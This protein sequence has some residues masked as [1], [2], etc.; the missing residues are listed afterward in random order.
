VS[1]SNNTFEI[2]VTTW[3]WIHLVMGAVVAMAGLG[4][5]TGALWARV[6][7]IGLV[8]LSMLDNFLFVPYY[9]LWSLLII[10]LEVAV[11]WALCHD[12]APVG[13]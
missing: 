8:G 9:P 6:V 3:G 2:D 4:V 12:A 7:G 11:I 10:A 5:L 13:P 1:T